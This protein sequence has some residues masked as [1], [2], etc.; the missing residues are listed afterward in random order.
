M[1][2]KRQR[3]IDQRNRLRLAKKS[4]EWWRIVNNGGA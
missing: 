1:G 3:W 2:A 4:R